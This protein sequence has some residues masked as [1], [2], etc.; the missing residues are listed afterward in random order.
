MLIMY[1]LFGVQKT[2]Y[3]LVADNAAVKDLF[4]VFYLYLYILDNFIAFLDKCC[5]NIKEGMFCSIAY[6][7]FFGGVV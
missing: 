6:N 3:H 2:L 4:T 7:N 1:I 5:N